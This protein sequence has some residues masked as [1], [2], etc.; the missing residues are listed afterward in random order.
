MLNCLTGKVRPVARLALDIIALVCFSA[1]GAGSAH[2]QYVLPDGCNAFLT[3]QSKSCLVSHFYNC[4]ADVE[5]F[6]WGVDLDEQGEM[7]QVQTDAEAGWLYALDM[8]SGKS[9]Y[10]DETGSIN[11]ASL[12]NLLQKDHD[13]LAFQMLSSSAKIIALRGENQFMGQTVII[14]DR[15]LFQTQSMMTTRDSM[16]NFPWDT[17]AT[18]YVSPKHRL[19]FVGSNVY[20]T[21]KGTKFFNFSR[22]EFLLPNE[23]G[24]LA[25]V[26]KFECES[27]MSTLDMTGV[28]HDKI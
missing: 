2:A 22:L 9:K 7:Y 4:H 25:D 3:V 20:H 27:I 8:P 5:G 12:T 16:G 15:L 18:E 10:L 19:F 28:Y 13:D 26:P 11:P 6:K 17:L 14:Y 1:F 24:F 21:N 23:V